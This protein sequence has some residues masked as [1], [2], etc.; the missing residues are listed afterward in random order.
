M[1]SGSVN[2]PLCQ[3]RTKQGQ[4]DARGLTARNCEVREKHQEVKRKNAIVREILKHAAYEEYLLCLFFRHLL[5]GGPEEGDQA[6]E[7]STYAWER[8][9]T[10]FGSRRGPLSTSWHGG[11]SF[12]AD[13]DGLKGIESGRKSFGDEANLSFTLQRR[14]A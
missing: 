2:P 12:K 10:S 4:L 5:S 13:S 8:L 9:S 1:E 14:I 7:T 6:G 11:E 3:T